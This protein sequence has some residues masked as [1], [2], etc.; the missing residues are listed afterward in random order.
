MVI[1]KID[2][3][4]KDHDRGKDGSKKAY[5]KIDGK[6]VAMVFFDTMCDS[7]GLG[8]YLENGAKVCYIFSDVVGDVTE[9]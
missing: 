4:I 3:E 8:F 9:L 2:V 1:N 5:L 6:R 7:P